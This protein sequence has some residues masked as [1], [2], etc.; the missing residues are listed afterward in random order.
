MVPPVSSGL[1][2]KTKKVKDS[3][4][5]TKSTNWQIQTHSSNNPNQTDYGRG[6]HRD[7]GQNHIDYIML[8][9]KWKSSV[10]SSRAFSSADAGWD[11]QL[12]IA[13]LRCKLKNI[14]NQQTSWKRDVTKLADRSVR[15]MFKSELLQKYGDAR[16]SANNSVEGIWKSVK[17]AFNPTAAAILGTPPKHSPKEWLSATTL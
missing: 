3:F 4:S 9:S 10:T 1:A 12:V 14:F 11:H 8:S 7:V 13:N 6:S 17:N 5:S 2:V 16:N 15:D